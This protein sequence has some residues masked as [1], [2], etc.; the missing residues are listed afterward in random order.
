[1]ANGDVEPVAKYGSDEDRCVLSTGGER[2]DTAVSLQSQH[3]QLSAA[4][5]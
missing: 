4:L 5:A 1:M 2:A 3:V